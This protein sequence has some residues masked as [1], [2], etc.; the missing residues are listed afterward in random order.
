MTLKT[1]KIR[2]NLTAP[3]GSPEVGI[4][5]SATLTVAEIDGGMVVPEAV[6]GSTDATGMA[7]LNLWP[8]ARGVAGSQYRVVAQR[9]GML[10]LNCLITVPDGDAS[11][12]IPIESIVNQAPFPPIDAAQQALA[13]AQGA[14]A[15]VTAQAAIATVQAGLAAASATAAA[16]SFPGIAAAY[17]NSINNVQELRT[18]FLNY[19]ASHP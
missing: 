16:D 8:N 7:L 3:N 5:L 13:A 9:G 12:E 17:I 2:V 15:P 18:L 19:I 6:Y 11:A 10:L 1:R 4:G 14:L